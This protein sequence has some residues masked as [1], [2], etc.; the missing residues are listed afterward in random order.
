MV[1]KNSPLLILVTGPNGAGKS[2]LVLELFANKIFPS[3]LP[4]VNPDIIAFEEKVTPVVAGRE[5]LRR[6]E[7]LL[8]QKKSFILETTFSGNSEMRL[9]HEAKARGY[10]IMLHFVSL[11]SKALSM[12]R[13]NMRVAKGGHDIP[14]ADVH[15]RF[16]RC[17]ANMLKAKPLA[18]SFF[19]YDNSGLKRN[20]LL[21]TL[22]KE[23]HHKFE[24]YDG[25]LREYLATF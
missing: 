11:E 15:R 16:E 25:R 12:A 10:Q 24:G 3:E 14:V 6:R 23:V 19:L 8:Q 20:A 17:Y 4:L 2:T 5:A 13:I 7:E 21:I 1:M 18:D 22:E 9:I